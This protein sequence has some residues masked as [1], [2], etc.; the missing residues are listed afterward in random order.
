VPGVSPE[1]EEALRHALDI[2]PERRLASVDALGAA[3]G[4]PLGMPSGK[5]LALTID[6]P[7]AQRGLLEAIV[8]AAAGVLDAAAASIALVDTT[9]NELVYQ[10]AW[11]LGADEI[12]GVRI[13]HGVGIAGDAVARAKTVLVGNCREDPRFA[14]QIAAGTGYVPHTMAVVPLRRGERAIGALSVLDRRDGEPFSPADSKRG[15]Y[16]ADLIVAALGQF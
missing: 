9:T 5:S 15:E 14:S 6:E 10:A 3:L 16:F 7:A 11:G 2:R 4:A 8:R 1:L 12:V 13:D